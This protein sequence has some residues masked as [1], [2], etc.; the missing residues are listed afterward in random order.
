MPSEINELLR[1]KKLIE[2][3]LDW[4]PGESWQSIDFENLSQLILDDTG[5]SLSVSTLR[6][7]WGRVEYNHLPSVTTLNTLAKFAGYE[8]WRNFIKTKT[9][10]QKEI[11]EPANQNNRAAKN[12]SAIK[13]AWLFGSLLIIGTISIFAFDNGDALLKPEDFSFSSQPITRG[14]PNSVVFTYDA[15]QAPDDS[16]FIQ[17]SWDNNKRTL[18]D[19]NQHKHTSI[20]Y[21]PGL[22]I[23]KLIIGNQVIRE[24][25]LL[26]PTDG[27]LGTIDDKEIPVYL[28]NSDFIRDGILSLP[29]PVISQKNI[30]MQPKPPV[31]TYSNVGNFDP[32]SLNDF[33]FTSE[34]KNEFREGAAVCQLTRITLFTD[35]IPIVIPLSVKGCVSELN[36]LS[37]DH[38]VSGK[39]ADLS[40]FGVDFSNWVEVSCKSNS[41]NIQ[42]FVNKKIAIEFP[43]PKNNV[44]IIG[45]A[46][47]FQGTGAVRKIRLSS[48]D[49]MVFEA[50]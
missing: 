28:K 13:L 41:S 23:A 29:I 9:T 19:K 10:A 3:K 33:S 38:Y 5:V 36:L 48:Q 46:Y 49:E 7:I 20:Y 18:V 32:V 44:R 2:Q 50:F 12:G 17:Q 24:H 25:K 1:C 11:S 42:Y 8:D 47:T 15:S 39:K 40:A 43:L 4:G 37:V 45:I 27:W 22:F 26:V 34:I 16:V 6:R 21:E 35:S 31:V 30:P 14:I